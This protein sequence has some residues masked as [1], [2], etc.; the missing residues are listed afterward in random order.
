[1]TATKNL[2]ITY[3][4]TTKDVTVSGNNPLNQTYH[5]NDDVDEIKVGG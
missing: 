5:T 2:T 1:M 3:P 4:E